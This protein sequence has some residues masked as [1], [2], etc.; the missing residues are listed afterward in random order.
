M[1]SPAR[2]CGDTWGCESGRAFYSR[3]C[4]SCDPRN[5]EVPFPVSAKRDCGPLRPLTR[6]APRVPLAIEPPPLRI[7]VRQ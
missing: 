2:K 5:A 3:G 4:C 1:A 6:D 7:R